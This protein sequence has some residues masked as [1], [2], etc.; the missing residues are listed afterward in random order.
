MNSDTTQTR[1]P[2]AV[3][4]TVL[5]LAVMAVL[6]TAGA[7]IFNLAGADEAGEILV[8]LV[9]LALAA[10][11]LLAAVRLPSGDS[12]YRTIAMMLAG[13]HGLFNAVIKV[14]IEGETESVMFIVLAA[15]V[16]GLLSLPASRRFFDQSRPGLA[17]KAV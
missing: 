17:A 16:V 9:F 7:F 15:A 14:G 10:G 6:S 12:R 1:R 2:A 5:V 13:A 4:A 8:G 11:Y 3:W